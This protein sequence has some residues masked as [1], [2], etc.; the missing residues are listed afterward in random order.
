MH[1]LGIV[2]H[3]MKEVEEIAVKNNA[4]SIQCVTLVVGEVS[5]IVNDYL[6]D[7]WNWARKKVD[8]LK[9]AELKINT[10]KAITFCEDCKSE[11]ETVKYG[12]VCPN[13]QSE[14]T[15]LIKGNET[16]IK[17]ILVKD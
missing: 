12:K 7:C 8:V 2:F 17:E 15:Y 5:S 3:I 16:I 11:Y 6:I 14:N 4:K 10:I 9:E 13:C 1:E